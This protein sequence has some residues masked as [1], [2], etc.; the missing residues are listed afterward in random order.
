LKYNLFFLK[1]YSN[2]LT[3]L[4]NVPVKVGYTKN[5][6]YYLRIKQKLEKSIH[7]PVMINAKGYERLE[8]LFKDKTD[9]RFIKVSV[10]SESIT[11]TSKFLLN[12]NERINE[13]RED[14]YEVSKK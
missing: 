14:I 10:L 11:F 9:E 13:T 7:V 3:K 6:G 12:L 4:A 5:R 2:H 8:S 1:E